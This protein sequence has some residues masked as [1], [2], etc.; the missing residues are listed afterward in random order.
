MSLINPKKYSSFPKEHN[1]FN[2]FDF[3][4]I[5]L[6]SK[7]NKEIANIS[8]NVQ[9]NIQIYLLRFKNY[10]RFKMFTLNCMISLLI[11]SL[12]YFAASLKQ[13]KVSFL[14]ESVISDLINVIITQ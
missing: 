6:D 7:N 12:K 4:I 9:T 14:I 8:L 13:D 1:A 3:N 11:S 2:H 10:L 5:S